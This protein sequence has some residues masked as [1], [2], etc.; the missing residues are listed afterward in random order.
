[1]YIGGSFTNSKSEITILIHVF[2]ISLNEKVRSF[3]KISA[4]DN[5]SCEDTRK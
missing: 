2:P 3:M 5:A 1:M 4:L